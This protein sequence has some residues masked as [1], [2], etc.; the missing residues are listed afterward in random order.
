MQYVDLFYHF[1]FISI[2]CITNKFKIKNMFEVK[3][4][5]ISI[6]VTQSIILINMM[7]GKLKMI[8]FAILIQSK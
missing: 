4:G 7:F 1:K 3:Y 6:P 5:L 2:F 8:I